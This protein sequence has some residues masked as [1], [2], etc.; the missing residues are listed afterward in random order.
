MDDNL[1]HEHIIEFY[2]HFV[3]G[4]SDNKSDNTFTSLRWVKVYIFMEF[5]DEGNLESELQRTGPM[6]EN[7]AKQYFGQIVKAVAFTHRLYIAHKDLKLE[8]F[9]LIM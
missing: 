8:N 5:A 3:I 9:L 4:Y 7:T 1:R 2:K 6:I